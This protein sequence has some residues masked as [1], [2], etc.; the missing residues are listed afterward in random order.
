M[1]TLCKYVKFRKLGVQLVVDAWAD[2][3]EDV[4]AFLDAE[5]AHMIHIKMPELGSLHNSVQ[6]VL[7]CRAAGV[8]ALL[9]GSCGE[10]DLAARVAA[11]VALATRPDL[12][13]AKPG[14]GVDEGVSIVQNEMARAL[15]W[16]RARHA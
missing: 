2:T 1:Q 6:A 10:T 5:A 11:H 7:A 15:T 13:L 3:L 9:G 14:R 4:Q 12:I 16:I 8:G